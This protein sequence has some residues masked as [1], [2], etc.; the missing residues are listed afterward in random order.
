MVEEGRKRTRSERGVVTRDDVARAV[1]SRYRTGM[2][3]G[4]MAGIPMVATVRRLIFALTSWRTLRRLREQER[5]T[6][7]ED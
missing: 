1:N 2:A 7:N 3:A 4:W 6:K 5:K